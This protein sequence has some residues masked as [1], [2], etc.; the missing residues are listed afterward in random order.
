[1]RTSFI[2]T[3]G[4]L[5]TIGL[6]AQQQVQK[7]GNASQVQVK[8]ST[9]ADTMEYT[10]GAYLGQFISNN[11]FVIST[12]DIFIKGMDDAMQHKPMRV[13]ADSIPKRISEYQ[14]HIASERGNS[15][16]KKLFESIKGKPGVGVLPSG[17]CYV[18]VK[19][20]AGLMPQA[21]DTVQL[22]VKAYLPDGKLFEDTYTKNMPYKITPGGLIA[23]L[24]EALQI[25]PVGSVWRVYIPSALAF[26]AKGVPGVVPPNSAVIF[27][28]ELVNIKK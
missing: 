6:S 13:N 20:G 7:P 14:A 21:T 9:A 26:A 28:V 18:I 16:E 2:V 5:F 1:M 25:M 17:V 4:L 11:G 12:P 15:E 3:F 22:Q 10:L 24:S 19:A 23:G 27:E 8:L